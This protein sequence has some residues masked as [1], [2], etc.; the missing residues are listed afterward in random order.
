MMKRLLFAVLIISIG[1]STAEAQQWKRRKADKYFE[2]YNYVKALPLY[3]TLKDKDAEV[4]RRIAEIYATNFQY[5]KALQAYERLI[6]RGGYEPEDVYKY[7]YYLMINGQTN[8]AIKWMN[9]YAD[10]RPKDIRAMKFLEDPDYY[11]KL[12]SKKTN[13]VV[14][15]TDINSDKSDFGPAYYMD[16]SIVFTSSRGFGKVWGGNYQHFL[17]LYIA[18]ITPDNNLKDV[19][20]FFVSSLNKKYHDGPASFNEYGDI[21]VVTRNIY[22]ERVKEN[23]LWLYESHKDENGKWSEPEPLSFN[24]KDYSCGHAALNDKGDVMFFASDMPGSYG[25]TDIYITFRDAD[26]NWSTPKNLGPDVNTEG[27]EMFPFYDSKSGYLFIT[28]DGLPGLGGLDI[29]VLKVNKDFTQY[30]LPQNVGPP[31]NTR[32]DDFSLA[33]KNYKKNGFFSSNR[34][35]GVGDDDIYGFLNFD[36]SKVTN[37]FT[38]SGIVQDKKTKEPIA[39]A[40]VQLYDPTGKLV[41]QQ[42]N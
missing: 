3:E 9:K 39:D 11:E 32:Y 42:I 14:Y 10:L 18:T 16:S 38:V 24:S 23:K 35:G 5:D 17:D 28:S 30:S 40:L 8:K 31:I 6:K 13:T 29:F 20:K 25:G 33:Y 7:A 21:M 2:E 41:R 15:L 1:V 22:G 34:K 12:L 19:R 26:G 36:A 37:F 4:Y 27:D